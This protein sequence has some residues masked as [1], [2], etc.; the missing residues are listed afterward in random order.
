MPLPLVHNAPTL[1]IRREA[2]ERAELTRASI[3]AWLNL[4]PEE[5]RVEGG[6]IAIGPIYDDDA[7]GSLIVGLEEKGLVYFDDII[8]MSGNLPAWLGVWVGEARS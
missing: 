8:E 7:L 2:F 3:D 6:V 5:F 1:L 4:T